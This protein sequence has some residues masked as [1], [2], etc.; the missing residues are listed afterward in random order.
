MSPSRSVRSQVTFPGVENGGR[1]DMKIDVRWWPGK[2][3][4]VYLTMQVPD[5]G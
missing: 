2:S 5:G 1:E 3:V 4:Y